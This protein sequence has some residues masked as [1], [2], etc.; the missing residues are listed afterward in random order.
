MT[1]STSRRIRLTLLALFLLSLL[2]FG[3]TQVTE[4][5]VVSIL[6]VVILL[7]AIGKN[8][9]S[10]HPIVLVFSSIIIFHGYFLCIPFP[11]DIHE[12]LLPDYATIR[13]PILEHLGIHNY[14]LAIRPQ[15]HLHGI[16]WLLGIFFF[17]ILCARYFHKIRYFK[18]AAIGI[19]WIAIS[20]CI[21]GW[22][23]MLTD[24]QSI[25]WIS[26]VPSFKRDI[27]F[28]TL[29][30]PNHAGILIAACIPLSFNLKGLMQKL[31]PLLLILG[32]I[33]TGSRGAI[34]SMLFGIFIWS[35]LQRNKSLQWFLFLG[36]FL[37]LSAIGFVWWQLSTIPPQDINIHNFT[38]QRSYIWKDS[39]KTIF[40]S[41]LL[42]IGMGGYVNAF[43]ITKT[44]PYY[45]TTSHAH[46]EVIESWI[47]F[48]FPVGTILLVSI[49]ALLGYAFHILISTNNSTRYKWRVAALCGC[50]TLLPST[51][52]D[53]PFS[54]GSI[55]LLFAF[56]ISPFTTKLIDFKQRRTTEE[57]QFST[58]TSRFLIIYIGLFVLGTILILL[59]WNNPSSAF[60][61]SSTQRSKQH[62]K[63]ALIST[64]MDVYT[65]QQYIL[66][67]SPE[68][69]LQLAEGLIKYSSTN[70][71][72]W[73][74]YAREQRVEK[75][76]SEACR[77]WYEALQLKFGTK[78]DPYISEALACSPNLLEAI[79]S[80]PDDSVLLAKAGFMLMKQDAIQSA[81]Y[82]LQKAA[83]IDDY[84]K[85][86]YARF[87]VKQKQYE[88]AWQILR[89]L[90]TVNC[91]IAKSKAEIGFALHF[92]ETPD[93]YQK[94][95]QY[96]G[97][98]DLYSK[99]KL[100]GQFR[101]GNKQATDKYKDSIE[102]AS[103]DNE[104]FDAFLRSLQI[105]EQ[106]QE[107]CFYIRQYF[108]Q[109]KN[110]L[111]TQHDIQQC[112]LGSLPKRYIIR[113]TYSGESLPVPK[114]D[115]DLPF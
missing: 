49:V 65:M 41:P 100:L 72:S 109:T 71:Y 52:V 74:I 60:S 19:I 33:S 70:A 103:I 101:N 77:G 91:V 89:H 9:I 23:Q 6:S 34:G 83:T 98:S 20:Y 4:Q 79:M 12:Q 104:I 59:Q 28:G 108:L 40:L 46:Q 99:H 86:K 7:F 64:P 56:L 68:N 50:L 35:I 51:L 1:S 96:C 16:N 113:S 76:Y 55:V 31:I 48:G 81:N 73:V 61:S 107:V 63:K 102:Y 105:Q 57:M 90:P 112:S 13:N 15:Q 18:L 82:V 111:F 36:L 75:D 30:N 27:F 66:N 25:Y 43:S 53:F 47:I 3:T 24:A 84:G 44:L 45:Q 54:I 29:I 32:V 14:P 85:E 78:I 42:G 97:N 39:W 110:N 67:E 80:I 88:F 8:W 11:L 106:S 62:F 2:L 21:L 10:I 26:D 115:T 93:Y 69:S 38:S 58:H 17:A 22:L 95:I 87:L 37:L 114:I 94:T 5:I 92:S